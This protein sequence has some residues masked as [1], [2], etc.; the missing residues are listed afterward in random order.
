MTRNGILSSV[1]H[2]LLGLLVLGFSSFSP[3]ATIDFEGLADGTTIG[4]TY[5]ALGVV[6]SQAQAVSAGISLNEVEFPPHSGANVALDFGGPIVLLFS[7]PVVSFQGF[8]TYATGI[9]LLGTLSGGS[10][11][12]AN[13][14]F[15][16]NFVSSGNPPNELLQLSSAGGIDTIT[17]TGDP[18]GGSF[19]VDDISFD[20][21]VVSGVPEPATLV[22]LGIGLLG[23]AIGRRAWVAHS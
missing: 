8:F 4:S 19:V 10:V 18:A 5:S 17:I 9:T 14:T 15:A 2:S 1:R 20:V 21:S 22:F 7:T 16:D 13:S 12:S 11:A 6:F 3:A 23:A